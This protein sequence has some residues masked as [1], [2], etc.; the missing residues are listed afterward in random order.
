MTKTVL[1]SK[2]NKIII[3]KPRSS[4]SLPSWS[5]LIILTNPHSHP[6]CH[7]EDDAEDVLD[8]QVQPDHIWVVSRDIA[9]ISMRDD[10]QQ[11]CLHTLEYSDGVGQLVELIVSHGHQC[12][13]LR[14]MV[15][16]KKKTFLSLR[17]S[18]QTFQ[19][20]LPFCEYKKLY[21]KL[22]FKFHL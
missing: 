15:M 22:F 7:Q 16:E 9:N 3:I 4:C 13:E 10:P 8:G 5:F 1:V 14:D 20:S 18:R 6:Q 2:L 19:I 12:T 11:G 17:K 21:W